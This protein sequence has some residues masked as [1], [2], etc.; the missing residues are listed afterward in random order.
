MA[1]PEL[2]WLLSVCSDV[3]SFLLI[4]D[5]GPAMVTMPAATTNPTTMNLTALW[6]ISNLLLPSVLK[7]LMSQQVMQVA[8]NCKI[9]LGR[10]YIRFVTMKLQGIYKSLT[11]RQIIEIILENIGFM[12]RAHLI[13]T[14]VKK[15]EYD[16]LRGFSRNSINK[17][18]ITL[19]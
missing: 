6:T 17:R 16:A 1:S 11:H 15:P 8:L 5:W 10:R 18:W 2:D 4:S 9:L 7:M 12:N 13:E 3:F 14:T 19:C